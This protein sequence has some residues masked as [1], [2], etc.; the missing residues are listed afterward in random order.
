MSG[1]GERGSMTSSPDGTAVS[2][3][4]EARPADHHQRPNSR[5]ITIRSHL[6]EREDGPRWQTRT[7]VHV[8]KP[9]TGNLPVLCSAATCRTINFISISIVGTHCLTSCMDKIGLEIGTAVLQ[10]NH[11]PPLRPPHHPPRTSTTSAPPASSH[12]CI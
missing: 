11:P 1:V 2:C 4:C 3:N 6:D 9:S 7:R 12:G 8:C 10:T 5:H